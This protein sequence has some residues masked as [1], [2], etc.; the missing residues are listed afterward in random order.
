MVSAYSP[1][2]NTWQNLTPLP[3]GIAG[4]VAAMLA[5]NIYYTG[6]PSSKTTYKGIPGSQKVVSFT[7][8]NADNE[9]AIQTLTSG[10]TLNLATLPTKNLNIRANTSPTT[11][12]SVVFNLSGTQTKTVT[13]S[14][15]PYALY[16]DNNY[17]DYYA[18]TPA[19]GS[20]TLKGTPYTASG[21][22]GTAGTSLTVSFTVTNEATI[23]ALTT[24]VESA[25]EPASK[26]HQVHVYPNPNSGHDIYIALEHFAKQEA[27]TVTLYDLLGRV[28]QSTD[29]VTDEQGEGVADIATEIPQPRGAYFIVATARSGKAQAR[30]IIN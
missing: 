8:I 9:Q 16:G 6:G 19:V 27:V 10:S 20:Y 7:L 3:K 26:A 28:L 12:G 15:A 4:G 24:Q 5:G 29:L 30:L 13:E 21:G 23:S 25:D 17:G 14:K 11:V 2:T 22:G 1:A 18:W